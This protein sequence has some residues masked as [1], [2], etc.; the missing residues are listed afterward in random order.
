MNRWG[1]LMVVCLTI[2]SGVITAAG[3][4][5]PDAH[6]DGPGVSQNSDSSEKEANLQKSNDAPRR[7]DAQDADMPTLES[8][9]KASADDNALGVPFLKNLVADQKAIWTSPAHLRWAD[10]SWLFP[11]TAAIAGF[12]ATDRSAARAITIDPTKNKYITFS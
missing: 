8:H 10:G 3:Q 1:V 4:A 5:N 9:V 6:A 2:S 7:L 11:L 12:F